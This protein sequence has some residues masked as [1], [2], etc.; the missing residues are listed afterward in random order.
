M[1]APQSPQLNSGDRVLDQVQRY[2]QDALRKMF[3]TVPIINGKMLKDIALTGEAKTIQHTLG[4]AYMGWFVVRQNA[5]AGVWE[6]FQN[7]PK[8]DVNLVLKA[9]LP[10]TVSLWVF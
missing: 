1:P 4:R 5:D 3:A 2:A 7:N 8:P 9:S 6:P 10:V